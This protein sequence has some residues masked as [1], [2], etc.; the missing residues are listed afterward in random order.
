MSYTND[1][2]PRQGSWKLVCMFTGN[3]F[4][5][6]WPCEQNRATG[7]N[8]LPQH[9]KYMQAQHLNNFSTVQTSSLTNQSFSSTIISPAVWNFSVFFWLLWWQ[10]NGHVKH[11]ILRLSPCLYWSTVA[12]LAHLRPISTV[13]ELMAKKV[14]QK[15][16]MKTCELDPIPTSLQ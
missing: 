14:G 7:E 12:C 6:W 4:N 15:S 9:K 11:L 2:G 13:S 1:A 5:L 10:N 8:I 16:V 3:S